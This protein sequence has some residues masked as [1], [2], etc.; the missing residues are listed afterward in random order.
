MEDS[1]MTFG[2]LFWIL[3]ILWVIYGFGYRSS[4]TAFGAW[5]WAGDWLLLFVLFA[6]LG[7]RVFGPALHG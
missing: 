1:S 5:G 4:P 7:W 2:L 3:M 6:L